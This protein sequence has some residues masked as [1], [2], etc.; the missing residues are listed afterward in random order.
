MPF[1]DGGS[2]LHGIHLSMASMAWPPQAPKDTV[3]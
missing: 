2:C 1:T 3:R